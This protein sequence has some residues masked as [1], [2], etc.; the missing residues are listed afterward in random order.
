MKNILL[1]IYDQFYFTNMNKLK[2]CQRT[3]Y[4]YWTKYKVSVTFLTL[5]VIIPCLGIL[6]DIIITFDEQ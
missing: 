1:N 2:I 3:F 5:V 6:K 4:I